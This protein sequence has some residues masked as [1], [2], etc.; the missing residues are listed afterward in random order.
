M[1]DSTPQPDQPT[2][3]KLT[4]QEQRFL[5]EY[6]AGDGNATQ[7]YLKAFPTHS[8]GT[9]RCE[10]SKLLANPS[11]LAEL[12]AVREASKRAL[13]VSVLKVVQEIAA[14]AFADIGD[15]FEPDP[16]G[17]MDTPK[18]LSKIKPLVRK[19]MQ[20]ARVKRRKMRQKGSDEIAEEVEEVEYKFHD[21]LAALEKLCKKLGMFAD[22]GTA[23]KDADRLVIG[24]E[25]VPDDLTGPESPDAES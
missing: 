12:D 15:A 18:P 4:P 2:G 9:A 6:I 5:D 1:A 21:K 24:G 11:I 13:R 10:S 22:A 7:A 3:R 19:A 14:V 17:G 20:S 23:A 8:Y 25:V 16:A